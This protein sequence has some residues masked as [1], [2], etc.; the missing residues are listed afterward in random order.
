MLNVVDQDAVVRLTKRNWDQ[1][2]NISIITGRGFYVTERQYTRRAKGGKGK[3][4]KIK[5]WNG[6]HSPR[7]GTDWEDDNAFEERYQCQCGHLKGKKYENMTCTECHTDVHYK[8]EDIEYMGWIVLKN[9][10]IIQPL[11][12]KQLEMVM[13]TK[14]IPFK[15]IIESDLT[16]ELDGHIVKKPRNKETNEFVGIGIMGLY[17]RFDEVLDYFLKRK[18]NYSELIETLRANKSA[19]FASSIPVY[20]SILRPDSQS[21]KSYSTYNVNK[22]YSPIQSK[23]KLLNRRTHRSEF[24][25]FRTDEDVLK[26]HNA[27]YSLQ[28][29]INKLWEDTYNMIDGKYGHIRGEITGGRMNFSARNVIIPD[30]SLRADEVRTGY[31]TFLELFRYEII[32][33]LKHMSGGKSYSHACFEWER[34]TRV[35]DPKVYEIIRYIIDEFKV[36]VVINRNP[37]INAKSIIYMRIIDVRPELNE[38]Q[39]LSMPLMVLSGLNADF[40]GDELNIFAMKWEELNKEVNRIYNPRESHMISRHDG[41]VDSTSSLIK[42]QAIGLYV[43]NNI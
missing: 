30:P 19:V 5:S 9:H 32:A 15:D 3:R 10:K 13:G 40:D 23:V 6:I 18:P 41:M 14:A 8:E 28:E 39:T 25:E 36:G 33:I 2:C 42:D 43:F 16:I 12:Y 27:L 22:I 31:T 4:E 17:E 7:F 20:T 29:K 11:Y 24:S 34:A 35:F 37:T 1:E 21:D 26:T 38:N